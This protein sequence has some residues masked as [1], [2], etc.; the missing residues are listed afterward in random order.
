MNMITLVVL[1]LFISYFKVLCIIVTLH[2]RLSGCYPAEKYKRVNSLL[3][4]VFSNEPFVN[5]S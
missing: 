1:Y 2:S 4:A 3:F 5:I